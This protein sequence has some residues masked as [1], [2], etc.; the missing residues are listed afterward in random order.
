MKVCKI[1]FKPIYSN[2]L[3]DF[4]NEY[5][6]ICQSCLRKF[7]PRFIKF[8]PL[9]G[10]KGLAIF[11]YDDEIR[12]LLYQFKG[13]FDYELKDVFISRFVTPLRLRFLGYLMV[14]VPSYIED[15]MKRGFNHVEE[16]FSSF[17]IKSSRLLVKTS[18]FK[19]ANHNS[20][21]RKDIKSYLKL[22]NKESL[23]GKRILLV[24]DVY[25]TGSTIK[26]SI[27]LLETLKPK[28]IF[29]LVMAKTINKN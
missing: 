7:K 18:H 28:E 13:C 3:F 27:H 11:D 24:D 9:E 10:Y 15:D 12:S 14:P 1:C 29:V 22:A 20:R 25:T 5:P 2:S 16:I 23:K 4:N 8:T 19:Q 26:A 17:K 21:Q 6:N